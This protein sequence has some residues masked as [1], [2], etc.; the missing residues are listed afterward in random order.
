MTSQNHDHGLIGYLSQLCMM[1]FTLFHQ[2]LNLRLFI[3]S[4]ASQLEE[5][6]LLLYFKH[7]PARHW[8]LIC[9]LYWSF[10]T[11]APAWAWHYLVT[12]SNKYPPGWNESEKH[13]TPI[14]LRED[15]KLFIVFFFSLVLWLLRLLTTTAGCTSPQLLDVVCCG[16]VHLVARSCI[17]TRGGVM[18]V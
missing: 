18:S 16:V 15:T 11:S 2:H 10:K 13:T 5:P 17:C 4:Y 14:P 7:I 1:S 8:F 9:S 12:T 6:S 3:P